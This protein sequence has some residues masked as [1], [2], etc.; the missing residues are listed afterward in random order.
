VTLADEVD[1]SRGDVL[2]DAT[3]RPDVADQFA[4]HVIWMSEDSLFPGR[5]YLMKVGARTVP[6]TITELKHRV[7]VSTLASHAAKTLAMNEVGFCNLAT[8]TPIAFDPYTKNRSTGSFILI[9]RYSNTTAAAGMI[10]FALRRA[11]NIHHQQL[12]VTKQARAQ[13]KRQHPAVL[14]FTG[15]SG[16]GKSTIANLVETYL[17]ARGAHSVMLDG[18]NVRH[19][20]NK[21]LGFTAADRVENIRRAGEVAKLMMEAGLIVLCSFI[22]PFRAERRMVRELFDVAEFLEIFVD[23]PVEQCI[24]RDPKGLYKNALAGKIKN[25]TGI[26]QPY[27]SPQ[28]PEIHLLAGRD[29]AE[30]SAERVINELLA[31]G[32]L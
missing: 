29:S 16:A 20:L 14:W 23:T 15:L 5:S 30:L 8:S 24:A 4:A 17:H 22:S 3:E 11:T 31:R 19:G 7:D 1:I 18:D 10:S 26:D 27:E 12:A 25:F 6:V 32:F 28:S 2:A 9:D 13:L 21:D